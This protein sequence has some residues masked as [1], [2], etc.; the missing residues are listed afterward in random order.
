MLTRSP[1]LIIYI[2]M[3]LT[4]HHNYIIERITRTENPAIQI[5]YQTLVCD[6]YYS[7]KNL[8]VYLCIV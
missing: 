6:D 5:K 4:H 2:I 1:T 7:K 8:C 3:F